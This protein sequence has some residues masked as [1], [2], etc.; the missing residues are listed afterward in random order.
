MLCGIRGLSTQG[1]YYQ[2]EESDWVETLHKGPCTQAQSYV[3]SRTQGDPL[4]TPLFENLKGL[5]QAVQSMAPSRGKGKQT[6]CST[7]LDC[8]QTPK[9]IAK[10]ATCKNVM[11]PCLQE[12]SLWYLLRPK[13]KSHQ[14]NKQKRR[15]KSHKAVKIK[16]PLCTGKWR[17]LDMVTSPLSLS[18][19][20]KLFVAEE[21]DHFNKE[22]MKASCKGSLVS[23]CSVWCDLLAT[24]DSL[25][26]QGG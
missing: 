4:C 13:V 21:R 15:R 12:I 23:A 10:H 1:V 20:I 16:A 26:D 18:S 7:C 3:A 5:S 11:S 2:N 19:C 17:L 9:Q 25:V 8:L 24:Q 6:I 14:W 22:G